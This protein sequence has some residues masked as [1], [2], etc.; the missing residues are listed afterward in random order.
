MQ[1]YDFVRNLYTQLRLPIIAS[2]SCVLCTEGVDYLRQTRLQ[3]N[4]PDRIVVGFSLS[5]G[6]RPVQTRQAGNTCSSGRV[7]SHTHKHTLS[8]HTHF[9][10]RFPNYDVVDLGVD[11]AS[12][13][14][15]HSISIRSLDN[16]RP[17]INLKI[18]YDLHGYLT[19]DNFVLSQGLIA[20]PHQKRSRGASRKIK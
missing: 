1:L 15:E 16:E 14:F 20:L 3:A 11:H 10:F 12:A 5:R 7:T 6:S 13:I 19:R 18:R 2:F 8:T 17:Q 4:I 9:E